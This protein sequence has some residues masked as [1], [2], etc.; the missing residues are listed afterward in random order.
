M[1]IS[2]WT[3]EYSNKP[4]QQTLTKYVQEYFDTGRFNMY[5]SKAKSQI[6]SIIARD[7][8]VRGAHANAE[9][10]YIETYDGLKVN[11]SKKSDGTWKA[12]ASNASNNRDDYSSMKSTLSTLSRKKR[13]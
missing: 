6:A 1:S 4:D 12:T 8:K 13:K 9:G 7:L 2:G 10:N 11:I 3:S 5:G